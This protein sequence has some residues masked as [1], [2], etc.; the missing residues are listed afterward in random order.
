V[1]RGGRL[2]VVAQGTPHLLLGSSDGIR[3]GD[4]FSV[5]TTSD[6]RGDPL[7]VVRVTAL[8]EEHR[9]WAP[10]E[11]IDGIT[12]EPRREDYYLRFRGPMPVP[13]VLTAVLRIS[14]KTAS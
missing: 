10:V 9:R 1:E 2:Q 8:R 11:V 13:Q 7:A 3:V 5:F 6:R 12:V 14:S 4:E